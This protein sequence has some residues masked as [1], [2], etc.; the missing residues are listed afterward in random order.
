MHWWNEYFTSVVTAAA[1][2]TTPSTLSKNKALKVKRR[3][4]FSFRRAKKNK[5]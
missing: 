5:I 1:Q 2:A 3:D 4:C